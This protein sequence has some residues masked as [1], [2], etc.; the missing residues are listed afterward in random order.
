MILIWLKLGP[1][2]VLFTDKRGHVTAQRQSDGANNQVSAM[3]KWQIGNNHSW[4][5]CDYW[6]GN[7]ADSVAHVTTGPISVLPGD[8]THMCMGSFRSLPQASFCLRLLSLPA[9]V[10]PYVCPSVRVCVSM[11]SLTARWLVTHSSYN[12]QIWT[13]SAKHF[14]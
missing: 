10:C 11:T 7:W 4:S 3:V 5:H 1:S 13:R 14:G 8:A 12:H 9:S 6:Y 2:S